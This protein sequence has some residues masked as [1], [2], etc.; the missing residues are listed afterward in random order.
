MKTK[1]DR[2]ERFIAILAPI[3]GLHVYAGYGDL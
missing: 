2:N 3:I 1:S